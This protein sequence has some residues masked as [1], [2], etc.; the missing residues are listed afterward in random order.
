MDR[1]LSEAVQAFLM[2]TAATVLAAAVAWGMTTWTDEHL[3]GEP[4]PL[5][6]AGP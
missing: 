4:E 5:M 3:V 2:A 1:G 6:L